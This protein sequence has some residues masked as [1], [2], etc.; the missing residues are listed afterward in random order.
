[1]LENVRLQKCHVNEGYL[2][3]LGM[4]SD[5]AAVGAR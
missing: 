2:K 4:K 5:I 3:A 1:L